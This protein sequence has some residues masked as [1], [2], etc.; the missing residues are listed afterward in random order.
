M[1]DDR[2][3]QMSEDVQIFT[4]IIMM[5]VVVAIFIGFRALW[6]DWR[7]QWDIEDYI[8]GCIAENSEV[9]E[10]EEEHPIDMPRRPECLGRLGLHWVEDEDES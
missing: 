10:I 4:L 2:P 7:K 9:V 1:D 3:F 5:L 6:E 8:A